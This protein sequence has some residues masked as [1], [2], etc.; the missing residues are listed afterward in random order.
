MRYTFIYKLLVAAII[1]TAVTACSNN[2]PKQT[3][4]TRENL[5]ATGKFGQPF[6]HSISY[7]VESIIERLK[8][9][10]KSFALPLNI[11]GKKAVLHGKANYSY[12]SDSK[13]QP[14][15]TATGIQIQ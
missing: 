3:K 11:S 7:S 9:E 1:M 10:N 2:S 12:H 6:N 8:T 5:P 13:A 15:I 14:Q 4:N